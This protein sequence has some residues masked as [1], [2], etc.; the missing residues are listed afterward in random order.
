MVNQAFVQDYRTWLAENSADPKGFWVIWKLSCGSKWINRDCWGWKLTASPGE[1][2]G[3]LFDLKTLLTSLSVG[4]PR[5]LACIF[6][7]PSAV[8]RYQDKV[9]KVRKAGLIPSRQLFSAL[10]A[11][12]NRECLLTPRDPHWNLGQGIN[13][14]QGIAGGG[15]ILKGASTNIHYCQSE[16]GG[17]GSFHASPYNF[18][19]SSFLRQIMPQDKPQIENCSH[20]QR[21]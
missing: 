18:K 20:F 4:S 11:E 12:A 17:P 9:C 6:L 7:L 8:W 5:G 10:H 15:L 13:L 16:Q 14:H 19:Y 2:P 21:V 3:E 1:D